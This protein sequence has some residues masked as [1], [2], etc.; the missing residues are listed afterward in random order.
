MDTFKSNDS[1]AKGRGVQFGEYPAT[2]KVNKAQTNSAKSSNNPTQE[3]NAEFGEYQKTTN[4][5]AMDSDNNPSGSPVNY[6]SFRRIDHDSSPDGNR[7]PCI[8]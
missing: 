5:I 8:P 7:P 2:K 3:I 1:L 6:I 4:E